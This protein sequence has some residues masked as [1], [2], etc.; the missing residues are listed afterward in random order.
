MLATVLYSILFALAGAFLW[1]FTE[2]ALHNWVGH[3][4]KGKREFSKQ[5]LRHHAE[6][7]W[8]APTRDKAIAALKVMAV[9]VPLTLW[10]LG[11]PYGGSF[12][13]GFM[14][15]YVAYEV[16][17]RRSHT[18]GP[19]GW[20]SRWVRKHHFYH[21]FKAP[22]MNHGVTTPLWDLVFRTYV[23]PG[24]IR[25]PEKHTMPWLVDED[26]EVLPHLQ[27]DYEVARRGSK[28]KRRK[29]AREAAGELQAQA[30]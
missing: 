21:H 14:V 10:L 18:H 11:Y 28:R 1:T 19:R 23:K 7:D 20:Y 15:M 12:S 25:V 29:K 16:V 13:A 3:L 30:A 9:M 17:H 5:H 22:H 4:S 2:Y 24:K 8:F 27:D 6:T 26:G